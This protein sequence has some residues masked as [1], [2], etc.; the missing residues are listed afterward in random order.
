M[1]IDV[2]SRTYSFAFAPNVVGSCLDTESLEN[3]DVFLQRL[4]GKVVDCN[5]RAQN[6]PSDLSPKF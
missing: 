6:H 4:C 5:A 3:N 1:R 2:P